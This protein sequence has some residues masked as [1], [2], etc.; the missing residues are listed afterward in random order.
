MKRIVVKH[1]IIS[2]HPYRLHTWAE[3]CGRVWGGRNK[4]F[5]DISEKISIFTP[6]NSDDFFLVIN[7]V[8]LILTLYF[9]ILCVFIVSNVIYDPFFTTK[10]PLSTKN[11]L[12]TPIFFSLQAF[13]PIPQHYFSKYWGDQCMGRPPTSN[14]GGP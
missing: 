12:T 7:Q 2:T 10:S 13:A 5:A 1:L 11:S 14:F 9:Q 3:T 8:F 4:F 6:K